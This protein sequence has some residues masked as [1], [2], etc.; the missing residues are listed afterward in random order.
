MQTPGSFTKY[1]FESKGIF[2]F[3]P[4]V[5]LSGKLEVSR[6]DEKMYLLFLLMKEQ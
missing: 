5:I 2:K 4:K 1:G 3:S 6:E